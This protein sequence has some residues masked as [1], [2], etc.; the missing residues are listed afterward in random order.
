MF[1]DLLHLKRNPLL[2]DMEL[3]AEENGGIKGEKWRMEGCLCVLPG[4]VEKLFHLYYFIISQPPAG[5]STNQT[6]THKHT[7]ILLFII[8]SVCKDVE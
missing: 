4:T 3:H 8:E 2:R 5:I 6:H 1:K 7:C